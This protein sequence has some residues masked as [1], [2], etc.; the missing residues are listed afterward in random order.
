MNNYNL[1]SST[2]KLDFSKVDLVG[3]NNEVDILRECLNDAE[4]RSTQLV[5]VRGPVGSGKSALAR[6]M[7]EMHSDQDND[8]CLTVNKIFYGE[9]KYTL[10]KEKEPYMAIKQACDAVCSQLII[11]DREDLRSHLRRQL[12]PG[13]LRSLCTIVKRLAVFLD[14]DLN[15]QLQTVSENSNTDGSQNYTDEPY[16]MTQILSHN[17]ERSQLHLAFRTFFQVL[18]AL[19]Y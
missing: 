9:G 16:Q 4:R 12:G 8:D 3:R 6:K 17:D 2:G 15:T 5:L 19:Q 13:K 14:Y 7:H 18:G 11:M 1:A 10:T